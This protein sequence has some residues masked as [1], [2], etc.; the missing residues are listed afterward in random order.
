[1]T[2]TVILKSHQKG[3]VFDVYTFFHNCCNQQLETGARGRGAEILASMFPGRNPS[4]IDRSSHF[5]FILLKLHLSQQR[6]PGG[7]FAFSEAYCSTKMLLRA[8]MGYHIQ[9]KLINF[10]EIRRPHRFKTI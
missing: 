3:A 6:K 1:M 2:L 5:I 10:I 9:P 4:S 8:S 7:C